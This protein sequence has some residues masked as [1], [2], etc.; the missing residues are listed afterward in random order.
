MKRFKNIIA[1]VLTVIIIV[2]SI[3]LTVFAADIESV[4]SESPEL[5]AENVSE[6]AEDALSDRK[7]TI[8]D[9]KASNDKYTADIL[10]SCYK[11]GLYEDNDNDPSNDLK[12]EEKNYN[13]SFAAP[14]SRVVLMINRFKYEADR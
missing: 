8:E 5:I 14:S 3:P 2:S 12:D 9:V 6:V 4:D 11:M 1:F 7:Y 13:R 10:W